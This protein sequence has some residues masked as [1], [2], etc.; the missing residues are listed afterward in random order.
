MLGLGFGR[1]QGLYR[2]QQ[3]KLVF[4][5]YGLEFIS[6]GLLSQVLASTTK[7]NQWGPR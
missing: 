2:A 3:V 5:V 7:Q 1:V 6:L 4:R